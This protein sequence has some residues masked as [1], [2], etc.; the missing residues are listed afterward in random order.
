MS[1]SKQNQNDNRKTLTI[2]GHTF[3]EYV[4]R[5]TAQSGYT[6]YIYEFDDNKF[7]VGMTGQRI[8]HRLH[9]V[10]KLKKNATAEGKTHYGYS[11]KVTELLK[12]GHISTIY[13]LTDIPT[14]EKAREIETETIRALNTTDSR[15]GYN[16]RDY[17]PPARAIKAIDK[18]TGEVV[19]TYSS[20]KSAM[21]DLGKSGANSIRRVLEG[22]RITAFGFKWAV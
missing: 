10:A 13:I 14:E 5:H 4:K 22:K 20:I 16:T 21:H 15:F 18:D 7:Y 6:C 8:S 3:T 1:N 17:D 12:Q 9:D 19:K 2:N 11:L